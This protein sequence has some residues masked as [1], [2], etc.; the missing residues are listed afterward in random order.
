MTLPNPWGAPRRRG[1][2]PRTMA[3]A[4]G[5]ANVL[6]ADAGMSLIEP[7][8]RMSRS[9]APRRRGD[10]PHRATQTHEQIGCSPQTRG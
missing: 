8:R 7:R 9:G 1:D 10:E 3:N 5:D 4:Q 6:P 2:E